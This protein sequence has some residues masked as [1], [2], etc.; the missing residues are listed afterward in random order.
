[1]ST[2]YRKQQQIAR[3]NQNWAK[4]EVKQSV[5]RFRKFKGNVNS[6]SK[7]GIEELGKILY[8]N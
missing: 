4:K 1:M 6:Y 7:I 8:G 2:S 5:P 3:S